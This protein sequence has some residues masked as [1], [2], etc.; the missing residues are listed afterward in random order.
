MWVCSW[1]VLVKT[2]L[3]FFGLALAATALQIAM[4]PY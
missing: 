2:A 4:M 1:T 3:L